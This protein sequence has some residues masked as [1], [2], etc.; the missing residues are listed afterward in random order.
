MPDCTA[1]AFSLIPS[2]TRRWP[3]RRARSSVCDCC[4]ASAWEFMAG[5]PSIK[6]RPGHPAAPSG[7]R[8]DP[9]PHP[10]P[11]ARRPPPPR[12]GPWPGCRDSWAV[13][14]R[15]AGFARIR[16]CRDATVSPQISVPTERSPRDRKQAAHRLGRPGRTRTGRRHPHR[17]ARAGRGRHDL[18]HRLELHHLQ[19][20]ADQHR[21]ADDGDRGRAAERRRPAQP[22]RQLSGARLLRHVRD[23]RRHRTARRELQRDP[24]RDR[25]RDDH[26]GRRAVDVVHLHRHGR[27]HRVRHRADRDRHRHVRRVPRR[28]GGGD[29]HRGQPGLRR[30][31][32][33]HRCDQPRLRHRPDHPPA[34]AAVR[35]G[36][37]GGPRGASRTA[38]RRACR[39]VLRPS[40]GP[41]RRRCRRAGIR[42]GSPG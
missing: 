30:L 9:R 8:T 10:C 39:A 42:G 3:M 7:G 18:L 35:R 38:I 29:L 28:E 17:H 32:H 2:C 27:A 16:R 20:R 15:Y 26:L 13:F 11:A 19:P 4:A 40:A 24:H 22:D 1:S 37:P 6:R 25:H 33:R 21:T 36:V 41:G 34:V 23:T 31:R 5:P 12:P 14:G